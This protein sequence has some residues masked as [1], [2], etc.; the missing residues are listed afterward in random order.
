MEVE[1]FRNSY[2]D[3]RRARAY[4]ELELGGTYYLVFEKLPEL[5]DKY[6]GGKRA[7]DFGC[8]TGRSTRFIEGLGFDTIGIDISE[9]MVAVARRRDVTGDYRVIADGDF[10][11]LKGERFDLIL[12]AFTFDN[13]PARDHRIRLF[14]GLG[15]LLKPAGILVNIVS[16]PEMY[17]NEWVTFTTKDF[18]EN[19]D[20]RCGDIVRIITRDY[21]DNRPVEDILWPDRDYQSV[22]RDSDLKQIHS[23]APLAT[24]DEGIDWKS[25]TGIAPWRI[26]ILQIADAESQE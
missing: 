3:D 8:G 5:L 1:S 16:T 26:Y 21:S 23:E 12:S 9:E 14:S 22:F 7:L 15:K 24:G 20:A 4:D 17:T 18:P 11:S 10:S 25:E 13:I 6:A 19:H 2:E